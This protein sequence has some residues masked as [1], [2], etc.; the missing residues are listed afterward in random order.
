MFLPP[1]PKLEPSAAVKREADFLAAR[2]ALEGRRQV[3]SFQHLFPYC[4]INSDI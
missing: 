1:D 2:D 4:M 3:L